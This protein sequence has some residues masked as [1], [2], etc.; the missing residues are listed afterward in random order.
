MFFSVR[1]GNLLHVGAAG[2]SEN[3]SHMAGESAIGE[4]TNRHTRQ[5]S[6]AR[7]ERPASSVRIWL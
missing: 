5:E 7:A 6:S 4:H 3:L 2:G 1:R